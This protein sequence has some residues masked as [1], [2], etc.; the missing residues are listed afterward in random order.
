MLKAGLHSDSKNEKLKSNGTPW[1][2]LD[3]MDTWNDEYSQHFLLF[4][5]SWESTVDF[6]DDYTSL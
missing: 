4:I 1:N 5:M 3:N 2:K 6:T